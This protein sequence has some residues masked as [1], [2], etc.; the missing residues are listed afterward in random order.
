MFRKLGFSLIQGDIE[1]AK[2]ILTQRE[3]ELILTFMRWE[4]KPLSRR[5]H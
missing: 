2:R 3:F 1:K 5:T 4:K